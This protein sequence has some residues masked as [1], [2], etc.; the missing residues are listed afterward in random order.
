MDV[1][2]DVDDGLLGKLDVHKK[3]FFSAKQDPGLAIMSLVSAQSYKSL[4]PNFPPAEG[5]FTPQTFKL[6]ST[7]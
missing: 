1:S 4:D 7:V 5:I 3:W 2:A 6:P